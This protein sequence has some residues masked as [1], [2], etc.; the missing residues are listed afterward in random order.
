MS[1]KSKEK[2]ILIEENIMKNINKENNNNLKFKIL[3]ILES[4]SYHHLKKVNKFIVF[5]SIDNILCLIYQ[6]EIYSIILII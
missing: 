3:D 4:K 6:N 1:E 5:K 2:N